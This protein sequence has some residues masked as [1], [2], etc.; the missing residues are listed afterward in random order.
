MR[1][2]IFGKPFEEF[3]VVEQTQE[4]IVTDDLINACPITNMTWKINNEDGWIT[5]VI[6]LERDDIVY[7][8]GESMH[9]INKRGGKYVSYN[10]DNSH[11]S[12]KMH[13]MYGSH[14]FIIIDRGC[15]K[16]AEA[17]YFDTPA[18]VVWDIDVDESGEIVVVCETLDMRLYEISEDSENKTLSA[19]DATKIFRQAIGQSFVPPMW[20]FGFCQSRWGYKTESDVRNVVKKYREADIPLDM[21]CMDIDYM[22]RYIDFTVNKKRFPD[23]AKFAGEMK[24]D[25]IHLVPIIDAGVKVEPGNDT[26]DEGVSKGF[27]CTNMEG[28]PFQA[29]VWPGMTHFPDF[30]Q[31]SCRKWF[32][33]KYKVLTDCGIDAF[34]NDMN[35]P[36]IFYSEYTK[37]TSGFKMLINFLSKSAAEKYAEIDNNAYKD[38]R[39]FYHY[40]NGERVL[41]HNVHNQYG[42]RMTQAGGEG[43]E[44]L[45]GKG[46]YLLYSRS[47]Y[48][49]SH[50]YGG[51]W[52]GDNE[53]TWD[54]LRTN[55]K[56]MASL[57]M[58]GFMYSG[59]DTG[60]FG[61]NCTRELLLRWLAFS[62]FTPLMRNHACMGTRKQECYAF[63][64]TE[65]FKRIINLRY[66]LVPYLYEQFVEAARDNSMYMRP[67]G[68]DYPEDRTAKAIEDQLMVGRGLMVTPI[69]HEG[70]TKRDVYVPEDMELIRFDGY[71]FTKSQVRSGWQ[72]IDVPVN[73]VVFFK[74]PEESVKVTREV[75][76]CTRDIH[77]DDLIEL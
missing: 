65:D 57:N 43:L 11:H 74:L 69:L 51:I 75:A 63:G 61:G 16:S 54:L 12:D 15:D 77:M 64:D 29:A 66:R 48:I 13:S 68:F 7:G 10:T 59:A 62:D 22:D 25:G 76:K 58:C 4:I 20:A 60:G 30:F 70:M 73:E 56:H 26:Y 39:H 67:L 55:V 35:E 17:Y 44:K 5:Y 2:Y 33:S 50:R 38:Y 14:N 9:G 37:K 49:G 3:S 53:S 34:W 71:T 21:V 18:R 6:P 36:S 46:N 24:S 41:H 52:T 19:Y 23:L 40:I 27:F 1:Q 45:L 47:S 72:Q 31:A 42:A 32:G 28:K 8:L